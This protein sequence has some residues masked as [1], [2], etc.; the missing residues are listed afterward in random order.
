M[1]NQAT[2]VMESPPSAEI[3]QQRRSQREK[4][5]KISH[6]FTHIPV[7]VGTQQAGA[8]EAI[9]EAAMAL[10]KQIAVKCP[11]GPDTDAAIAKVLEAKMWATQALSHR[12][13]ST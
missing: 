9:R 4:L 7:R 3:E 11:D 12:G 6:D 10:A 1:E 2:E 5:A 8:I 13:G